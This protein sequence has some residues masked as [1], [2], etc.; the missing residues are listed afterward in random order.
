[1]LTIIII[2]RLLRTCVL[3]VT[4]D[5][6]I[7]FDKFCARTAQSSCHII[8]IKPLNLHS[9]VKMKSKLWI[10]ICSKQPSWV[11]MSS[12]QP[13]QVSASCHEKKNSHNAREEFFSENNT[14]CQW[15]GWTR[16]NLSREKITRYLPWLP[17]KYRWISRTNTLS[18]RPERQ[19]KTAQEGS[20]WLR[21]P[22]WPQKN[23]P[24]STPQSP[25]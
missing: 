6:Q 9:Q 24:K 20:L 4:K 21:M 23:A 25:L 1:M 10:K 16:Q 8:S 22:K 12:G 2:Y 17:P 19:Q 5:P 7:K 14:S 11:P 15:C 3:Q 13:F 18:R